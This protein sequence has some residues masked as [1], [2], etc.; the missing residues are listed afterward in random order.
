MDGND[1][2]MT[3]ITDMEWF[4]AYAENVRNISKLLGNKNIKKTIEV[5]SW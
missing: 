4:A 5:K 3:Y 2:L 1:A